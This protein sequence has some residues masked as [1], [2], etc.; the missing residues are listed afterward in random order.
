MFDSVMFDWVIGSLLSISREN[1]LRLLHQIKH[2]QITK[3]LFHRGLNSG[4]SLPSSR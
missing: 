1:P 3:Q 4:M 2:H